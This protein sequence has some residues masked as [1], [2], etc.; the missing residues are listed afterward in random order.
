MR[1]TGGKGYPQKL[2]TSIL[3]GKPY[4]LRLLRNLTAFAKAKRRGRSL[5]LK[6]AGE[7]Y[8]AAVF[9]GFSSSLTNVAP[10]PMRLRR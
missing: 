7:D 1:Q 4:I 8:F 3:K 9:T 6:F 5:A 10:L 2:P